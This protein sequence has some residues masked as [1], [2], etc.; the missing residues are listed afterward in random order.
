M[1]NKGEKMNIINGMNLYSL[2]GSVVKKEVKKETCV[3]KQVDIQTKKDDKG[4]T[5]I[6]AR[7]ILSYMA[8]QSISMRV[9]VKPAIGKCNFADTSEYCSIS[10]IMQDFEEQMSA[11]LQALEDEFSSLN[12]SEDAKLKI[13]LKTMELNM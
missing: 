5:K 6:E 4:E 12:L 7:D 11:G 13:M 8:Q 9:E 1:I 10:N 2:K 3:E